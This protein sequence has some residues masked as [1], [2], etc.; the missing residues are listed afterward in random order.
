MEAI[1]QPLSNMQ[2][3][4]LKVFSHDLKEQELLELKQL[5]V[6]FFAKRAIQATNQVWDEKG[7][8]DED[9]D[10]MLETKMR[11]LISL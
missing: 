6:Q 11:N 9:V 10:R 2:L 1:Q 7:W 4:L 5:L 3:E 8:T